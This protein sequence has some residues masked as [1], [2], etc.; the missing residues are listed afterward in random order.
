MSKLQSVVFLTDNKKWTLP[1]AKKWLKEHNL[2]LLKGKD[3]DKVKKGKKIVQYRFRIE[4][5]KQ[6]ERFITKKTKDDINFIIGYK[7]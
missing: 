6:F 3:I 1:K 4:D 2:K 7:K 5:P